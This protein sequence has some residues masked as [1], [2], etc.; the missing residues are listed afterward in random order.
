[1][2]RLPAGRASDQGQ[3]DQAAGRFSAFT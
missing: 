3:V 2:F 1:L